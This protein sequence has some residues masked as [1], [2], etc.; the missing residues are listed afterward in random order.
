[1]AGS[2]ITDAWERSRILYQTR[3]AKFCRQYK[4]NPADR[5]V[6]GHMLEASYVLISVFGLTGNQVVEIEKN[7]GLTN[8]D[9]EKD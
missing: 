9:I 3:Y 7:N 1:M 6:Q 8:R 5:E 2:I 4:K